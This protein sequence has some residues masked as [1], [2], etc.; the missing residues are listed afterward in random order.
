MC[1]A[2]A[3]DALRGTVL[4]DRRDYDYP[5]LRVRLP[6]GCLVRLMNTLPTDVRRQADE[7]GYAQLIELTDEASLPAA[8]EAHATS[9]HWSRAVE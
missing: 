9:G 8:G 5:L 4:E 7:K 3:R 6:E 1:D 2:G